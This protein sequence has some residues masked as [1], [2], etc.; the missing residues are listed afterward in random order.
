MK[1]TTTPSIRLLGPY[2]KMQTEASRSRVH[3]GGG[4]YPKYNISPASNKKDAGGGLLTY[5]RR[6]FSLCWGVCLRTFYRPKSW[7]E[8]VKL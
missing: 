8:L 7:K 4:S 3:R 1:D 2:A 6:D 5:R